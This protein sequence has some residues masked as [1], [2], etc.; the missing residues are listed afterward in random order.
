M[1]PLA[2]IALCLLATGL[3][4]GGVIALAKAMGAHSA[5]MD[6]AC[7][8]ARRRTALLEA[9]ENGD[10]TLE[11]LDTIEADTRLMVEVLWNNRHY[12]FLGDEL[13]RIREARMAFLAR[14]PKVAVIE[15]SH[16][17]RD[18]LRLWD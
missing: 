10:L 15:L 1:G 14:R 12:D 18:V 17:R 16:L 2:I 8:A 13:D 6:Q 3:L 7:G 5:R 9:C 4:T 11:R